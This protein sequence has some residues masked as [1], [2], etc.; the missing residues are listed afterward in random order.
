MDSVVYRYQLRLV[1][2]DTSTARVSYETTAELEVPWSDS[3]HMIPALLKAAL[4][5]YPTPPASTR[6]VQVEIGQSR[7]TPAPAQP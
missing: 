3:I 7:P 5:G 4:Q 1:M 2:R 6:K